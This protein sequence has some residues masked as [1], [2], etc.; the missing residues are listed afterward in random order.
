[1]SE[2]FAP[3]RAVGPLSLAHDGADDA[4]R[5]PPRG[6]VI[7]AT[8]GGPSAAHAA[9]AASLV[10][11]AWHVP[12][13][14][15]MVDTLEEPRVGSVALGLEPPILRADRDGD[16]RRQ[17]VKRTAGRELADIEWRLVRRDGS[18]AAEI[19]REA[20][21][22]H[23]SLV[24]LGHGAPT[25]LAAIVH[26]GNVAL[27]AIRRVTCPVLVVH[28]WW[29]ELPTHVV[30][31]MDFSV[32]SVWA[33]EV[34]ARFVKP[35]GRLD[36]VHVAPLGAHREAGREREYEEW[37]DDR[38]EHVRALLQRATHAEI[39]L[40]TSEGAV[41][42][43]LRLCLGTPREALLV[44]GTPREALLVVGDSG[45][46][47]LERL[48]VG[49]VTTAIVRDAGVS[50][51]AVPTP[52]MRETER[53]A[54]AL[55]LTIEHLPPEEWTATLDAFSRRN[56]GRVAWLDT[57]DPERGGF[58]QERGFA[59]HGV[60]YDAVDDHVHLMLGGRVGPRSHVTRTIDGARSVTIHVDRNGR[61]QFLSIW[62]GDGVTQLRLGDETG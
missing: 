22:R 29:S 34:A 3:L 1:M 44:V 15:L 45:L 55:G 28:E 8:D 13:E 41:A 52:P 7:V 4:P 60:T 32:S 30:V 9:R 11:A 25:A 62:R 23:A 27:R 10:A 40:F 61:E 16:R 24:V 18:A 37:A 49:S 53:L 57:I 17:D 5:M 43:Q 48:L 39:R 54:E 42:A 26:G 20:S 36:V 46:G 38:L 6:P 2:T 14:V 33:A 31:G 51:L 58:A 56:S 21:L 50:V 47:R 35:G 59:F 19:A 12:V